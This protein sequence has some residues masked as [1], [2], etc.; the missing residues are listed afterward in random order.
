MPDELMTTRE[1]EEFLQV[2]RTT[3]Y[4]ML[5]EGRLPGFKVGGQWRFSK[6]EIMAWLKTQRS[7]TPR[8]TQAPSAEALSL[9][10]VKSAQAIFAEAMGVGSVLTQLDG[11]PLDPPRNSCRFCDLVLSTS[12]GQ[13]RCVGSWRTLAKQ[14]S[15]A[16][17]LHQCHAGLLYARGRIEME[18]Q[19]VA[20]IFAGQV[21][22][23]DDRTTVASN[24][25]ALEAACGLGAGQL[26]AALPAVYSLSAERAQQLIRLLERTGETLASIGQERLSLLRKL[27][28]IAQIVTD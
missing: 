24:V 25:D 23:D 8:P 4:H 9:E 15:P 22:I 13:R 19:F 28:H 5:K 18:N 11:Q 20:M 6:S 3:L 14:E 7:H 16:P 27:H 12:E 26:R 17:Q 21:V 10:S 2:D 1:L